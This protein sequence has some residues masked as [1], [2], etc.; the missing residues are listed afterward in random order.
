M[1]SAEAQLVM[2]GKLQLSALARKHNLPLQE[3]ND[4]S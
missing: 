1:Q 3:I 2:E 4:V